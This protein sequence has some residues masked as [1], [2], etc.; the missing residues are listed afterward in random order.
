VVLVAAQGQ[1]PTAM[2]AADVAPD[3]RYPD[4]QLSGDTDL[5]AITFR[6]PLETIGI[7]PGAQMIA[8][9]RYDVLRAP[10]PMRILSSVVRA[11]DQSAWTDSPLTDVI[12]SLLRSIDLPED[13]LC[14]LYSLGL[15]SKEITIPLGSQPIAPTLAVPLDA[16]TALAAT[17]D[18]RFFT[19]STDG[20]YRMLGLPPSTPHDA[21]FRRGDEI[22]LL[23]RDGTLAHGGPTDLSFTPV[24][25]KGSTLTRTIVALDG[26][27]AT[28]QLELFAVTDRHVL[29][30]YDGSTWTTLHVGRDH[31]SNT[32]VAWIG[33]HEAIAANASEVEWTIARAANG[34]V[35][36]DDLQLASDPYGVGYIA[37]IGPL[38][39]TD[40]G[41]VLG[42]DGTSWHTIPGSMI[43]TRL[44]IFAHAGRGVLIG[45]SLDNGLFEQY[46]PAAGYCDEQRLQ[47]PPTNFVAELDGGAKIMLGQSP[48]DATG[49]LHVA[50]VQQTSTPPDC[51]FT[52]TAT[53]P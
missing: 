5:Y 12:G 42:F 40:D 37:G 25:A 38:I 47:L 34:L 4:V 44:K 3:L 1:T 45:G 43:E 19:V 33:P 23:S 13:N 50:I 20:T 46:Q 29:E 10:A 17:R 18:G 53:A 36:E 31:A 16:T 21:G 41:H 35:H 48:F 22:W 27:P 8:A 32:A 49:E 11:G 15:S 6:C 24:S 26:S 52:R 9:P 30:T 39:G 14:R 28:E 2:F 51:L 7:R